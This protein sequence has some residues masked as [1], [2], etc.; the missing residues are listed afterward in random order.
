MTI[1]WTAYERPK[2][3]ASSTHLSTM[4]IDGTLTFDAVPGGTRMRWSWELKMRGLFKLIAPI[5]VRM[6]QHQEKTIWTNLKHLLE[7][8]PALERHF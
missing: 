1:E 5:I 7:A 8:Q 2:R 3:L 4:E 6:G